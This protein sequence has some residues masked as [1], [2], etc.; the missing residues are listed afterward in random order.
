[1]AEYATA[2]EFE[3]YV[4]DGTVDWTTLNAAD[5]EKLLQAAQRDVDRYLRNWGIVESNGWRFGLPKT[6]NQKR[7]TAEQVVSLSRITCA[8]AEYRFHMGNQFFARDQ[9]QSANGPHFSVQ[10]K[11]DRIGPKVREELTASG[12][13]LNF[14]RATV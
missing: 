12:M 3:I 4:E 6:T 11:L 5:L 2:A 7:L 10:G 14:T 8:R 13:W 9:R 1:M